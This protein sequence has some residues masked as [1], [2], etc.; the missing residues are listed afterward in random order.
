MES[1]RRYGVLLVGHGTVTNLASLPGFLRGIRHGREPPPA[2]VAEMTQ[3]YEKIGGSPLLRITEEQAEALSR[4]L[5]VPVLVGM[6]FGT[7]P[8]EQ[9][10]IRAA[11]L[12]LDRLVVL[13]MAPFSVPLYA[14][15]T[16]RIYWHLVDQRG[17]LGFKLVPVSPWSNHPRFIDAHRVS[18]L[19]HLGGHT[20]PNTSIVLTAHS[21]PLRAIEQGDSYA[22][23]VETCARLIANAL[24]EEVVVAYQS[25]GQD[26]VEWLGP[27]LEQVFYHLAQQGRVN[28]VVVPVG[29]LSEHVETLF[30]LDHDAQALATRHGLRMSRVPALN[31]DDRLIQTLADLVVDSLSRSNSTSAVVNAQAE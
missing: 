18:I 14:A 8:I 16:E 20:P 30:D 5:E 21:L 27:R 1:Q 17:P 6:R 9:A 23:Q 12:G 19:E 31:R 7:S 24:R 22:E 28:V 3:R 25:Q 11:S 26:H 29:F 10:L 15:E 13:P 4:V 2:L